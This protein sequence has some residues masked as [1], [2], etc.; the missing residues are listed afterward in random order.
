MEKLRLKEEFMISLPGSHST[1]TWRITVFSPHSAQPEIPRH[2]ELGVTFSNALITYA[3]IHT[4]LLTSSGVDGKKVLWVP[5]NDA[6]VEPVSSSRG[7]GV[8][9][10]GLDLDHRNIPR[11]VLR[12]WGPVQWL[13]G[14]RGVVVNILHLDEHLGSG[15]L[16]NHSMVAGIYR[17]PV[18]VLGLTVQHVGS[19]DH[20]WWK[21]TQREEIISV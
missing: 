4:P 1:Y 15:E 19:V 2:H 13:W 14:Q 7:R 6:V 20:P 10:L 11:R 16:G 9:V 5:A 17:Q 21:K 3:D 8:R 18:W 12:Y